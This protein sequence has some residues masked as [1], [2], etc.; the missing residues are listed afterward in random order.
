MD[1]KL[2][3]HNQIKIKFFKINV[4]LYILSVSKKFQLNFQL[5]KRNKKQNLILISNIKF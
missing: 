3:L 2:K 4:T 5:F 1:S